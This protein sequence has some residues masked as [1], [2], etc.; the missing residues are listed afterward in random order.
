MKRLETAAALRAEC[1][2]L[3]RSGKTIGFVPTMGALHAGHQRLVEKSVAAGHATVVSIFVNPTQFGDPADLDHY[4]RS[5]ESDLELLD[6]TGAD[7][8][9]TP[10]VAELYPSGEFTRVCVSGPSRGLCGASRPG[11]FDGVATVVSKFFALVGSCTAY[12]GKKDY[13]QWL[14]VRGLVRDLGFDVQVVGVATIR[15]ADGLALSSRNR[16]LDSNQRAQALAVVRGLCLAEQSFQAG[17]RRVAVLRQLIVDA[18]A[19]GGAKLD[20]AEIVSA[21]DLSR[22]PETVGKRALAAVAAHVGPVRL[23]DN[24]VLGEPSL[25]AYRE[26]LEV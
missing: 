3:R 17:E 25:Q 7:V 13:Q 10:S 22:V 23:I 24:V 1:N 12:F 15:E 9:F 2:A 26:G 20:Y 18:L 16:R 14:V 6:A 8:V 21:E 19:E 4:P 11:H 5:L